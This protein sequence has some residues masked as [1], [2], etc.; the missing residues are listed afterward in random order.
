MRAK[1]RTLLAV[2]NS[3]RVDDLDHVEAVI[4]EWGPRIKNPAQFWREL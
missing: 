2:Q 3:V 1:R 4:A